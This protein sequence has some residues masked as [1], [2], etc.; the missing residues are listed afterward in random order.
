MK[1]AFITPNYPPTICGVGDHTW[2]LAQAMMRQ[3]VEVHIICS[4][5]Q[6]AAA[7][8]NETVH[9]VVEQWNRVGVEAILNVVA[10]IR[11]DWLVV[12]NVPSAFHPKGLPFILLSLYRRLNQLNVP[13]LTVFH[14]IMIRT[15]GNLKKT[16]T[17]FLQTRVIAD[18]MSR[19]SA[20]IVT[21]IDFY[22]NV[23]K[24]WRDRLTLIPIGSNILP[25]DISLPMQN[26][27]RRKH[28][29]PND[30]Q[31]VCT[32]GNRDVTAYLPDFDKLK[33]DFP[34]LIWLIC[35][36]T[37]T[38]SVIL[39]SRSYIRY[40]GEMLPDDIYRHLSLGDV[41]FM[42][43]FVSPTGEGGTCNKSGSLACAMWLGIPI[44]G[45]K[46][47]LNNALLVDGENILL[48]DVLTEN[49]VYDA[50]KSCF[51][52][53][54]RSAKLGINALDFYETKLHWSVLAEQFL[55]IMYP[56]VKTRRRQFSAVKD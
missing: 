15:E 50:L 47:D 41:F 12:Q 56:S 35:G 27:L 53:E 33:Q 36:R 49:A 22:G 37:S 24:K 45:T 29:I 9:A 6:T 7:A 1:I 55:G 31:V 38:P 30:A 16:I 14:E 42:P 28:Q 43:D 17:S 34:N 20:A 11:P 8:T 21:S 26:D 19:R 4:A 51:A 5:S 18:G 54:K 13:I 10:A 40:V 46:G 25:V 52:S 32:F 39:K 3:G 48:T 23:L 2:H 44:V